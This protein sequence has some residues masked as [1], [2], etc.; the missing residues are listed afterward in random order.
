MSINFS[1]QRVFLTVSTVVVLLMASLFVW[2]INVAEFQ[3]E[4]NI[5]E[6]VNGVSQRIANSVIPL[7]Y[8]IYQQSTERH[9]TEDTA[10][11]ILD[12]EL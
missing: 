12:A 3:I 9:F 2:R 1:S 4:R 5:N 10:S 6:R 7:V 11:A 8:N